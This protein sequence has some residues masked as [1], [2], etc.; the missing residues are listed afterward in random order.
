MFALGQVGQILDLSEQRKT[1]GTLRASAKTA[2]HF[3]QHEILL[4]I[5]HEIVQV[6]TKKCTNGVVRE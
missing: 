5:L 1:G 6:R 4:C 2:N 3:S